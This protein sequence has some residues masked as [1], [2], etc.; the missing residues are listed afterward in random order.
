MSEQPPWD[1][2]VLAGG[3]ASR[4]GGIDKTALRFEGTTL[5][6]LALAGVA[7][8][9]SV[10]VV[11]PEHLS[12]RL[13]H[14]VELLAEHPRF[15][16]PAAATAAGL[17][18]LPAG[19]DRV[20]LVAA[21]L[22]HAPEAMRELLGVARLARLTDGVVATDGTGIPQHLLG[23]YDGDALEAAVA[24]AEARGT[25]PGSSMRALLA[26]LLLC[27]VRLPDE[28]CADVDDAAAAARHGIA[29]ERELAHA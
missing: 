16:G 11:G 7:G 1:A 4:L 14:G 15:G 26:P 10:V 18:A 25:L 24:G 19:R 27:R 22:P 13:P 2:I 17:R 12:D 21:D 20:A 29:I 6:D 5:L 28:L 9:R 3:R 23:V 8:A